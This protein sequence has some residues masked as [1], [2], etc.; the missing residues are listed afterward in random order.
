MQTNAKKKPTQGPGAVDPFVE[1][2]NE[3]VVE[4]SFSNFVKDVIEA[5]RNNLIIIDFWAPWCGPCKQLGPMLE[6]AVCSYAG[7]IKLAKINIDKDPQIARQMG[8]QSVPTVFA[9]IRGQPVDGFVGVISEAQLKSWLD[10]LVKATNSDGLPENGS[11]LD[12]SLRQAEAFISLKEFYQARLVYEKILEIAPET[13][14]A[15]AGLIH[16]LIAEGNI[17]GAEKALAGLEP[18]VSDSKEVQTVKEE[19]N[20]LKQA[21][22]SGNNKEELEKVLISNPSNHQSRFDLAMMHYA[23]GDKKSA[24]DELLEIVAQDK[25]W[26]DE[27]ARKQLVKLFDILGPTDELTISARKRLSSL[28]FS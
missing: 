3:I 23:N 11:E 8:V 7:K 25:S 1:A 22:A 27:A 4:V 16:C 20:L 9:F 13:V 18:S 14:A 15:N 6:K 19:I 28:L 5:S 17:A 2:D 24:V 12:K 21:Q 26:N 10:R